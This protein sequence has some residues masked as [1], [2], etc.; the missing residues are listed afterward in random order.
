MRSDSL[1]Q[2]ITSFLVDKPGEVSVKEIAGEKETV[3]ELRVAQEDIG[4][5]I[6]KNGR[7]AKSLRTLLTASATK[8]GKSCS[9][10]IID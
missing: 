10:E 9:L 6:G 1:I 3:L 4:K 8:E 5:V 7:I 2:Y